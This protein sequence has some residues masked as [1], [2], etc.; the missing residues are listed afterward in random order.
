[1]HSP[2]VQKTVQ[3]LKMLEVDTWLRSAAQHV[4][5]FTILQCALRKLRGL[6]HPAGSTGKAGDLIKG[7]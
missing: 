2:M 6:E 7:L 1:M 4:L 3:Q 5:K